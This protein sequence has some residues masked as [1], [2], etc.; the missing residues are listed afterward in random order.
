MRISDLAQCDAHYKSSSRS[1]S[2]KGGETTNF[3]QAK[4]AQIRLSVSWNTLSSVKGVSRWQI[5]YAAN[6]QPATVD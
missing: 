2:R 1:Q 5:S 6:Y 3:L 4:T